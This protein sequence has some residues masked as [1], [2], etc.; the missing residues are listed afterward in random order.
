MVVEGIPLLCQ[1]RRVHV[2]IRGVVLL[3]AAGYPGDIVATARRRTLRDADSH[4]CFFAS[5]HAGVDS[6][7]D[8]LHL[9]GNHLPHVHLAYGGNRVLR[10]PLVCSKVC[11]YVR[12][13]TE[14]A[15]VEQLMRPR[16][17]IHALPIE[18][19]Y[20]RKSAL[21]DMLG[22]DATCPRRSRRYSS[23]AP[24]RSSNLQPYYLRLHH[25]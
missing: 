7:D 14:A 3:R 19:R 22:I 18:T 9:H 2:C 11:T 4:A 21:E 5:A 16:L 25:S 13:S 6:N 20:L 12:P 24:R 1:Q 8:L 17:N 10:M 23:L 15:I